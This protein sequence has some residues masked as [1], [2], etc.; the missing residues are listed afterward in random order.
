MLR[1]VFWL[2]SVLFVAAL[3]G[4]G[5]TAGDDAAERSVPE[6]T[7]VVVGGPAGV[8]AD[9]PA[10]PAFE[11]IE[12]AG[13]LAEGWQKDARLYAVAGLTPVDAGGRARGWLYTYVSPSAGAVSS[14][15][16]AGGEVSQD[17]EQPLPEADIALI[18]E[19]ALPSAE[20][21]LDSTE[22]IE[23]TQEV[24]ELLEESP[25]TE[26]SAGLD[27]FSG[28]DPGWIFAVNDQGRRVEEQVPATR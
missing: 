1:I 24:K 26:S 13:R 8:P 10:V 5:G 16:V 23:G 15:S 17:P 21:L 14:I 7:G 19:R 25:G 11:G 9:A 22:A 27:S 3:T 12:A 6:E 28:G 20:E 4:C 18:S 2:V